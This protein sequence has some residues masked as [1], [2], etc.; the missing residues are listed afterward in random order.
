MRPGALASMHLAA[1]MLALG[2]TPADAQTSRQLIEWFGGYSGA[3]LDGAG[4][5]PAEDPG[6][7]ARR[8]LASGAFFAFDLNVSPHL[9][10]VLGEFA[11]QKRDA[12]LTSLSTLPLGNPPS[13][14]YFDNYQFLF[15]AEFVSGW[16]HYNVVVRGLAGL[17]A[18]H[19]AAPSGDP[20]FPTDVFVTDFGLGLAVG[21][22]LDRRLG[23]HWGYRIIQFDY[24]PSHMTRE[25]L[26]A[27]NPLLTPLSGWQHNAR[28]Q[29]GIALSFGEGHKP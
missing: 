23:R 8:R 4:A 24:I 5:A 10:V 7:V 2:S 21:V 28:L 19:L 9:R 16:T 3:I 29:T 17:A 15:G 20:H 18:R 1:W 26:G 22:G 27:G 14:A 12:G 25:P 13:T 11:W 6:A